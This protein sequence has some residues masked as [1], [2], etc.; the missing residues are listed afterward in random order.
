MVALLDWY[1][2]FLDPSYGP[3]GRSWTITSALSMAS[4]QPR[5]FECEGM[6]SPT[7]FELKAE[8]S[9]PDSGC[10]ALAVLQ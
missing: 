9:W 5:A 2:T 10:R 3:I 1:Y 4:K 7:A 6:I 8:S